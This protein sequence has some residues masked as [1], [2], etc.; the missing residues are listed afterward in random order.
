MSATTVQILD[1]EAQLAA[2]V[3]E[4]EVG[5]VVGHVAA[6]DV[7]IRLNSLADGLSVEFLFEERD[8]GACSLDGLRKC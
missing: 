4:V 8:T 3:L 1:I 2:L 6:D 7:E 5:R